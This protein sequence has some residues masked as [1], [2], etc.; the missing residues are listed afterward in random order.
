MDL[1][2]RKVWHEGSPIELTVKEFALLEYLVRHQG[3][4]CSRE[5]LLRDLWQVR[6]D[7]VTNVVDVYINYLRKKL[8]A[9]THA[10][11]RGTSLIETVR[12]FGYRL[13]PSPV[14]SLR[15]N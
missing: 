8:A 7:A 4:C 13:T 5:E 14:S 10:E 9:S 3:E 12:G 2:T 6:T 15:L 1:L 11:E